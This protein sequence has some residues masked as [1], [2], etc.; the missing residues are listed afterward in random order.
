MAWSAP[1]IVLVVFGSGLIALLVGVG[2]LRRR[3][4]PMAAPLAVMLFAVAAWAI[5]HAISPGYDA[6]GRVLLWQQLTYPGTMIGP[7]AYLVV[8]ITYAGR[9]RWLSRRTYAALAVIP[10]LATIVV[11]TAP[12]SDLFWRDAAVETVGGASVLVFERGLLNAV[13]L[14][15]AYLVTAAGLLL[16]ADVVV[17]SGRIYRT[18]ASLMFVGGVVPLVANAASSL[19]IPA[20]SIDLTTTAL[21]VIAITFALALFYSSRTRSSTTTV[22]TPRCR[23]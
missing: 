22:T 8:V 3:P 10:A 19:V 2:S 17:R 12:T 20:P 21:A 6:F 11:W 5:P 1:P 4:D 18:Q 23:S 7:V 15:Y 9:N 13:H 14:G 16:F